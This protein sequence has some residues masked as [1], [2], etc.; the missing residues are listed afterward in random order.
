MPHMPHMHHA[1]FESFWL[2]AAL[3]VLALIYVRGWV[4][5]RRFFPER[6][7]GWRL[8]SF[9]V[10]LFVIWFAVASPLGG[11]DHELLT[12]HML[13]HLLLMTV[14]APL[15]WLGAPFKPLQGGLPQ[16][17]AQ[18]VLGML[19]HWAPI[20]RLGKALTHPAA[21]WFA[22][23]GTLVAWHIPP[24]FMFGMRSEMW[25]GIEQVSFLVSGL[26]FWWPVVQPWP[27]VSRLP[28]WSIL[29][30]LFFATLPC[31]ILS[32]FLVFCDR[33][34]YPAYCSS[35]QP[36]GLSPLQDQQ[37]AASLMWTCVTVV[38]L[39]AGTVVAARL[40]SPGRSGDNWI[41][42][43]PSSTAPPSTRHNGVI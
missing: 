22:A 38:Y 10:G 6:I 5:I 43:S 23:A 37:C 32:G 3:I 31:D 21:C 33:V 9:F 17:F 20:K 7:E 36:F 12:A 35:S 28:D 19:F 16:Q 41:L 4:H 24:V 27:A 2:S 15:I 34:V 13:Q 30:Y 11:F 29:L 40:L 39:I 42:D 1:S 25:H 14:A 8:S 26:L 18:A